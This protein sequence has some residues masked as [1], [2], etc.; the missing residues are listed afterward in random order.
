VNGLAKL[1][2]GPWSEY[3]VVGAGKTGMDAVL[4]LL[5]RQVPPEKINMVLPNDCWF[6]DRE[7][8]NV[9]G[10][11]GGKLM[12]VFT[13]D[14]L[15]TVTDHM[16]GL[17]KEGLL[18][19]LSTD[20]E[21]NRFRGA[22]VAFNEVERI[23]S[24]NIV[25]T[26]RI[27]SIEKDKIIFANGETRSVGPSTLFVDCS[28]LSTLFDKAKPIFEKTQIN[29]QYT[30]MPPNPG[31]AASTIAALDLKYPDNPELKNEIFPV[32]NVPQ[33][34][35]EVVSALM[36]DMAARDNINKELGF[37]WQQARRNFIIHHL[38]WEQ[39]NKMRK[40]GNEAEKK[41]M[42]EK[43]VMLVKNEG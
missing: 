27:E 32:L 7:T 12:K 31:L 13:D 5:K 43:M 1:P 8:L 33:T 3:Y 23:R 24:V 10:N 20:I 17:E 29:C 34:P 4:Y 14:S 9:P 30:T 19:R 18:T 28:S 26:G 15:K 38:S 35:V 11:F 2:S 21:P 40:G 39:V 41:K 42:K 36:C 6:L 16:H 25:R 22:V 37:W